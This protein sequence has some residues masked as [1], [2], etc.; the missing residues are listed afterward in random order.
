MQT[1]AEDVEE[2]DEAALARCWLRQCGDLT[3]KQMAAAQAIG[4][5]RPEDEIARV[6]RVELHDIRRWRYEIPAFQNM[7]AFWQCEWHHEMDGRQRM[8]IDTFAAHNDPAML[9]KAVKMTHSRERIEEQRKM[10]A[11]S[12]RNAALQERR[13]EHD[14]KRDE[15]LLGLEEKRPTMTFNFLVQ[16]RGAEQVAV[17]SPERP[18]LL[19]LVG[20]TETANGSD[21]GDVI[22]EADCDSDEQCP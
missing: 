13:L 14:I 12:Q 18:R 5:G 21:G 4:M 3:A 7:V 22:E 1:E 15:R 19:A 2:R 16:Q 6:L 9:E 17:R 20:A 8:I 11:V 10:T